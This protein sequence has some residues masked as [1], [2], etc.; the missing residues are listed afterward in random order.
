MAIRHVITI[1]VAPGKAREFIAAFGV[2][3]EA[4]TRE[5]GC[6]QYALFQST[7][8]ADTFVLLERW[9]SQQLI[10]RHVAA[11]RS[12]DSS[13]ANAL[14]ALWADGVTPVIER[15]EV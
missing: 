8:Q 3:Q 14:V 10:D 13:P 11:E 4:V 9:T 5:E 1:P 2:V 15:Y 7:D 6:E 12:G